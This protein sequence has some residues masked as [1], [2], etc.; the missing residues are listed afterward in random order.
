MSDFFLPYNHKLKE[1]ARE[2]RK[3]MTPA[4]RKLWSEYLRH[5]PYKFMR[6]R[7]IDNFIVDFY[8][9][10]KRLVIELDG[11]SHFQPEGIE[12]D[13]IRTAILEN[14]ALKVIRFNNHD[15]LTNFEGV[16][17]AI[18]FELQRS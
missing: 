8:C 7:P 11:D 14:Y 13:N 12:R 6:Q 16:C 10:Q 9:S 18:E 4:E 17:G 2:L 1:R 5:S 3:N 15:V